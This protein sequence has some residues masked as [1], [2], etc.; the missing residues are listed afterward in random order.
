[1]FWYLRADSS[2]LGRAFGTRVTPRHVKL[3]V[4]SAGVLRFAEVAGRVAGYTKCVFWTE[5]PS[6]DAGWIYSCDWRVVVKR[7]GWYVGGG[8]GKLYPPDGFDVGPFG[9]TCYPA[10]RSSAFCRRYPPPRPPK[11]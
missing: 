1:M 9:S 4:P 6:R 3:F 8:Y 11:R 2:L 7:R 10:V 5:Y